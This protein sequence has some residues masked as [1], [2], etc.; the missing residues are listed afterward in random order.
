MLIEQRF[1]ISRYDSLLQRQHRCS[2]LETSKEDRIVQVGAQ[3]M[4]TQPQ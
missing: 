3:T 2:P 1:K 4:P